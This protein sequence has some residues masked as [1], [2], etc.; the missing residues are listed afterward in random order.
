MEQK[1]IEYLKV[2]LIIKQEYNFGIKPMCSLNMKIIKQVYIG[3]NF[4]TNAIGGTKSSFRSQKSL[5]T[6]SSAAIP[7]LIGYPTVFLRGTSEGH[8][9]CMFVSINKVKLL[10]MKN[11]ILKAVASYNEVMNKNLKTE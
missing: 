7:D 10:Q 3:K 6:L 5:V 8:V 1:M 11:E 4:F 2:S 9:A